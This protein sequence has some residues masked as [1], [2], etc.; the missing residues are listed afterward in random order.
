MNIFSQENEFENIIFNKHCV[1]I[2]TGT[3]FNMRQDATHQFPRLATP[4]ILSNES[5]SS[6]CPVG[7]Q[8]EFHIFVFKICLVE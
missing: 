6:I 4:K 5:H 2:H 7:F 8:P 3:Q 1:N